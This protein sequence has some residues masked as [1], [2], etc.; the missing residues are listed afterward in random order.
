MSD[1]NSYIKE[2]L[3][4]KNLQE[5]VFFMEASS[6]DLLTICIMFGCAGLLTYN[7]IRIIKTPVPNNIIDESSY[8]QVPVKNSKSYSG[9]GNN[10]AIMESRK[11]L[12]RIYTVLNDCATAGTWTAAAKLGA[13]LVLIGFEMAH[14]IH[15][16]FNVSPSATYVTIY[17]Y[18]IM[19]I[20]FLPIVL[21]DI[22]CI[23]M[24]SNM[25]KL[26]E[27]L[28]VIRKHC[29]DG[30][31][32]HL[33]HQV[34]ERSDVQYHNE[35]KRIND[36]S[37][38]QL[39]NA[40]NDILGIIRSIEMAIRFL[41]FI[42][43]IISVVLE[44][45]M[46]LLASFGGI[47]WNTMI[48]MTLPQTILLGLVSLGLKFASWG[49]LMSAMGFEVRLRYPAA[50]VKSHIDQN[51]QI[52]MTY[53]ALRLM[54]YIGS[55][56]MVS[57]YGDRLAEFSS[58]QRVDGDCI[59]FFLVFD[60]AAI[61]AGIRWLGYNY[62][63][64]E[65]LPNMNKDRLYLA[66]GSGV[67]LIPP[68][69]SFVMT[70]PVLSD[71]I[72]FNRSNTPLVLLQP[73]NKLYESRS[74]GEART[75]SRTLTGTDYN[76]QI[77]VQIIDSLAGRLMMA[78][79][80]SATLQRYAVRRF[81]SSK[82]MLVQ[83]D[84][85]TAQNFL[86]ELYDSLPAAAKRLV[87]PVSKIAFGRV[88]DEIWIFHPWPGEDWHTPVY[89]L[90]ECERNGDSGLTFA[91]VFAIIKA[92]GQ[93]DENGS[94]HGCIDPSGSIIMRLRLE[95]NG[96]IQF[97]VKFMDWGTEA[98]DAL[99]VTTFATQAE[100]G[101]YGKTAPHAPESHWYLIRHG[102]LSANHDIGFRWIAPEAL[103]HKC[104][105]Q[106]GISSIPIE[107]LNVERF[108]NS[109]KAR[110]D[111]YFIGLLLWILA[112]RITSHKTAGEI[113]FPYQTIESDEEI[114]TKVV[115]GGY[116]PNISQFRGREGYW[117]SNDFQVTMKGCLAVRPPK[118][119]APSEIWRKLKEDLES[120]YGLDWPR[121]DQEGVEYHTNRTTQ[122]PSTAKHL[123]VAVQ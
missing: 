109:T 80:Q 99:Q 12:S 51:I 86:F 106:K 22:M 59:I 71:R 61:V 56:Q 28:T 30:D 43:A 19:P 49:G 122:R 100:M 119:P 85:N 54:S 94:S 47:E 79:Q 27:R 35:N 16:R 69:T 72:S 83:S 15:I 32:Y 39:F 53:V 68:N 87:L 93:L 114:I 111:V 36:L 2:T 107:K 82:H 108:S 11:S 105:L 73:N 120:D 58:F 60:T 6:Q 1:N 48:K 24:S 65:P 104:V 29:D 21:S 84:L 112:G 38:I 10:F 117:G 23:L 17:D 66:S 64:S 33:E 77:G 63:N 25:S 7:I 89:W 62:S 13:T 110:R 57:S 70:P 118:R 18:C 75:F 76:G 26:Y 101:W 8:D 55:Q 116:R 20:I 97:D 37:D 88:Q 42:G 34:A 121:D 4:K 40:D 113:C 67:S 115:L 41:F 3:R 123:S 98:L 92:L 78:E 44:L 52:A 91:V 95:D 103:F 46:F 81:I 14:I 50:I 74:G 31:C 90:S 96:I 102:G 45:I 9:S 5:N